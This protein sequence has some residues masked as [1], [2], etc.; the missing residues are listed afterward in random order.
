MRQ[1]NCLALFGAS[2]ACALALP[3]N[4]FAKD[5]A[6]PAAPKPPVRMQCEGGAGISND[7][8]LAAC[9]AV[10]KSAPKTKDALAGALRIRCQLLLEKSE[11]GSAIG[12]CNRAIALEPGNSEAYYA[13]AKAYLDKKD[14]GRAIADFDR[15]IRLKPDSAGAFTLRGMAYAGKGDYDRAIADYTQALKL[16]PDL[17]MAQSLLDEARDAKAKLAGGQKPGDKRAW[18]DGKALPQEGFAQDLQISGCT[19]LIRSGKEK[20]RDLAHDYFN[21]AEA[22][23]FEGKPDLAI[24][25]YEQAIKRD[26]KIAEAYFGLGS[27]YWLKGDNGRAIANL[28]HAVAIGKPRSVL[29]LTYLGYAH[30]DKG[31]FDL[32]IADYDRA[33]AL[34]P[35]G[36]DAFLHR[37]IAYTGKGDYARALVDCQQAIK[38]SQTSEATEGNNSCGNAHFRMGDFASAVAD[39]DKALKLWSEYPEALYGRGAA[40]MHKGDKAGGEADIAAA[41]KLYSDVDTGEGELGIKP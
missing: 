27:I 40:R 4:A 31:E 7:T 1:H 21:R 9:T 11:Y 35:D 15:T 6:G 41:R 26:P 39:Y 28:D 10:I 5:A 32:A 14:F 37:S 34:Q 33:I 38:L 16:K 17:G 25:D 18:C 8:Q 13:R 30:Y 36:A 12:D 19:A 23:N 20:P 29:Y 3:S 2:L 24:P 22:Y